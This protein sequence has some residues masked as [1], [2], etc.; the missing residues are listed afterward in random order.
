MRRFGVVVTILFLLCGFSSAADFTALPLSGNAPLSTSFT[1]TASNSPTSWQW[2]FGDGGRSTEQN[3]S[4]IYAF[5][6]LYS[7]TFNAID[8]GGTETITKT[9]YIDVQ[10]CGF[11]YL[12]SKSSSSVS[13]HETVLDAYSN[14]GSI[15][16]IFI[17]SRHFRETFGRL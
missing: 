11:S 15:S 9:A 12:L 14:A 17:Q 1:G 2:N 4:H 8:S 13:G 7:V 3:P 10:P 16:D 6:G 5:P